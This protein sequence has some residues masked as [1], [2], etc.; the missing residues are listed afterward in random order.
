MT[1]KEYPEPWRRG[2]IYYFTITENGRR[3]NI[4]TGRTGKERAREFV[5]SYVDR[6]VRG[7]DL[8][9]EAYTDVFFRWGKC[10]H[11]TRLLG[12]NKSM[13]REHAK[14]CRA[15]LDNYVLSDPIFPNLPMKEIRRGHILDLRQ[16]LRTGSLKD[17]T[18]TLNKVIKTVKTVLAEAYYREDI[19]TNPGSL[20][21]KI[22]YKERERG[23]FTIE[24]VRNIFWYRPGEMRDNPLIDIMFST[25]FLTGARVGEL[26]ALRW[27][28]VD[29]KTGRA[30]IREAFKSEKEIGLPKWNKTRE[31][32]LPEIL[33][34]RLRVWHETT[35]Y[36]EP[37][38]FIFST[39]DGGPPGQDWMKNRMIQ[40]LK[41]AENDKRFDFEAG[42]R[43]L[44]PHSC[45]HT[46]NNALLGAGISPLLVQ[47]FLGWSSMEVKILTK[48]QEG[49]T[50]LELLRLEDVA[51]K[52]DELYGEEPQAS[53]AEGS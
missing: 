49:Y 5:R 42:D 30:K 25:M 19:Q 14:H 40:L 53:A 35:I 1:K 3:R 28:A 18:C 22:D 15:W 29:D 17:K 44:T 6:Q 9:L 50:R 41:A 4:S 12:E 32:V 47:S 37:D 46:M 23:V 21:G 10:P 33:L 51:K 11:V 36:K 48:I 39:I 13:S 38:S 34:R 2:K 26:R 8:T 16:R 43:W 31:I 52:L 27:G 45:R 20:I 7:A 24:E